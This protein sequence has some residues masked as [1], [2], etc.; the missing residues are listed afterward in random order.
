MLQVHQGS[1]VAYHK[2]N[3]RMQMRDAAELTLGTCQCTRVFPLLL[4]AIRQS[5]DFTTH[6]T[7]QRSNT[8]IT[9]GA[10]QVGLSVAHGHVGDGVTNL[11]K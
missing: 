2:A 8:R 6:T 4:T 11:V 10:Q 5:T 1:N 7:N 9:N 3:E